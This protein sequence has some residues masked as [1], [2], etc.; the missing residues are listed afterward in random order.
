VRYPNVA[1]STMKQFEQDLDKWF[2]RKNIPVWV[3]EY[4]NETRPGEP[5]GVT[6]AQQAV[7]VPQAISFAK[8]DA[9]IPMF[10]W[11]VFRDSAGS[12]WQSGV[13]RTSGA[14]KPA[15]AKWTAAARPVDKLNGKV[16]VKGGTANPV[17]TVN[18]RDM[19]TN[20]V[21]GTPVGVFWRAFSGAQIAA[22]G[23]ASSTLVFDCTV[24]VRLTG[25]VVAK[26]RTYRTEVDA[27][28]AVTPAKQRV[29]TIVGT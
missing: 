27:S 17:I 6:E 29:I 2:G 1:F 25:L 28:T 4:G 16:S 14:S 22:S 20:N 10:I 3:T 23:Q 13:H 11:F 5:K 19:C 9:R 8:K 24:T 26:G 12:P 7:Y 15:A 21:P 18:F